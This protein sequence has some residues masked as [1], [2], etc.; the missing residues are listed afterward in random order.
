MRGRKS[1]FFILLF[2]SP[3][4]LPQ[5]VTSELQLDV[6]PE[7]DDSSF[8]TAWETTDTSCIGYTPRSNTDQIILPLVE[9]GSYNFTVYW[10]DGK[11]DQ[12]TSWN[13]AEVKHTYSLSGYYEVVINGELEGW[14]VNAYG[15]RCKIRYVSQW[16]DM[17]LGDEGYYFYAAKKVTINALDAPDLSGITDLSNMFGEVISPGNLNSWNVSTIINM[18]RMFTFGDFNGPLDLWDVSNVKTMYAMFKGTNFN[19][20]ISMWNVSQV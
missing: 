11:S 3:L 20:D 1:I 10:G 17:K 4:L 13:Q 5:A 8:I 18:N 7:I 12:I 9:S 2:I 14:S 19:Q 6:N 16:G 15:D